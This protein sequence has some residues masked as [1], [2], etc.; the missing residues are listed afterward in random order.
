MASEEMIAEA[1]ERYAAWLRDGEGVP[2]EEMLEYLE[3]R[4][5]GK[6]LPL[7]KPRRIK[8]ESGE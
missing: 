5:A 4:A 8:P 3:K 6:H 2:L 1:E 7:P